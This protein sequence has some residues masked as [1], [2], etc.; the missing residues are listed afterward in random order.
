[1]NGTKVYKLKDSLILNIF[2]DGFS[3]NS[4][5]LTFQDSIVGCIILFSMLFTDL[6]TKNY[7]NKKDHKMKSR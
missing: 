5:K 4:L 7:V 3:D 6:K 2:I 1:M